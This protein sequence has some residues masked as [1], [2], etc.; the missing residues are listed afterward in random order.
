VDHADELWELEQLRRLKAAYFRLL[1]TKQ[2][3]D[4]GDL[5]TEDCVLQF[6]EAE[7]DVL[8]GRGTIVAEIGARLGRAVSVHRGYMPE[9]QL[10]DAHHASGTWGM[11]SDLVFPGPVT[12]TGSGHYHDEYRRGTDGRWRIASS[13]LTKLLRI[14][15]DPD[16]IGALVG[17]GGGAV[18]TGG[19]P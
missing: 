11:T 10:H 7:A 14:T 16:A 1:D 4:W 13:R 17:D 19:S 12:Q 15:S 18:I 9:L 3:D 2:W 5:L 6:G 8:R